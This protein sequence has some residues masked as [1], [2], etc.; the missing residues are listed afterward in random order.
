MAFTDNEGK[1][2]YE[3]EDT[4]AFERALAEIG[5]G[6]KDDEF[7]VWVDELGSGKK[8]YE[9]IY[10]ENP[11]Q[12][13]AIVGKLAKLTAEND[14]GMSNDVKGL[15]DFVAKQRGWSKAQANTWVRKSLRKGDE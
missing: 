9:S 3:P 1:V 4:Q 6:M 10:S 11:R 2:V 5:H 13:A 14:I 7:N 15:R 8:E 12:N